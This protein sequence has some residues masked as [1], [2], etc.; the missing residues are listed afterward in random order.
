MNAVKF[1][2]IVGIMAKYEADTSK[3]ED[4]NEVRFISLRSEISDDD[5]LNLIYYGCEYDDN[6]WL[7][8]M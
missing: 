6:G 2:K 1:F 5:Q 7:I 4:P 8:R 3:G